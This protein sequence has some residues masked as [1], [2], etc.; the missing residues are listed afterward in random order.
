MR[1]DVKFIFAIGAILLAALIVYVLFVPGEKKG[2]PIAGVTPVDQGSS[3]TGGATG[4]TGATGSTAATQPTGG[5]TLE[6]PSSSS[7]ATSGT[8]GIAN[9]ATQPTAGGTSSV[10]I[11]GATT[12]PTGAVA[13]GTDPFRNTYSSST[14]QPTGTGETGV[15]SGT[16]SADGKNVDWGRLLET[17]QYSASQSGGAGAGHNGATG[18]TGSSYASNTGSR[19]TSSL[20]PPSGTGSTGSTG[21]GTSSGLGGSS[22]NGSTPAS[23][24]G[25]RTHVVAAGETLTS[26]AQAEYG[27]GSQYNKILAAN[28]KLDPRKIKVG[29]KLVIPDASAPVV[30][31]SGSSAASPG[32]S[33]STGGGTGAFANFGTGSTGTGSTGAASGSAGTNVRNG[34]GGTSGNGSGASSGKTYTVR[35]GDSLQKIAQKL[36]GST[37]RWEKIYQLNKSKIGSNPQHIK[38][39]QVLQ[40]PDAPKSGAATTSSQ[41]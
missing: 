37:D 2:A 9:T 36:Y 39:G 18:S 34:S 38:V 10:A 14:T 12:Q 20:F 35:A 13:T 32:R 33:D 23:T 15:A 6:A 11:G 7:S 25:Q 1:K 40:L 4:G 17:G 30:T 41:R 22:S 28:P 8:A 27:D 26:I 29:Q 19:G 3:A 24:G 16:G 31:A 5:L 21:S